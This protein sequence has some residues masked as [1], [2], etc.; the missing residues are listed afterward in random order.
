VVEEEL[1]YAVDPATPVTVPEALSESG[2]SV[3]VRVAER[4]PL[5]D[6]VNVTVTVQLAPAASVDPQPFV[7][8]K[9]LA[10]APAKPIELTVAESVPGLLTVNACVLDGTPIAEV[11]NDSDDGLTCNTGAGTTPVPEREEVCVRLSGVSTTCRDAD[12]APLAP[13]VNVT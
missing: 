4:L 1:R 12:R 7:C 2:V 13:G 11:A 10:F 9:S 5:A 3:T 6:A 8:E